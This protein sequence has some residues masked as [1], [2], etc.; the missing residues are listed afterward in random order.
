MFKYSEYQ[1]QKLSKIPYVKFVNDH[2]LILDLKYKQEL[3]DLIQESFTLYDF[4]NKLEADGF[5]PDLVKDTYS[6]NLYFTLKYRGRP[7]YCRIKPSKPATPRKNPNITQ[8]HVP[9]NDI[10][11]S[12]KWWHLVKTGDFKIKDAELCFSDPLLYKLFQSFPDKSVEVS[13]S[14]MGFDPFVIGGKL[15]HKT[16]STFK[17]Y[18]V[19][20]SSP[21]QSRNPEVSISTEDARLHQQNPL[22]RKANADGIKLNNHF[23]R[24]AA[25]FNRTSIDDILDVFMIDHS[26]FTLE[27]KI[28]LKRKLTEN[29]SCS[30][31]DIY[32]GNT[33]YHYQL[34]K[35]RVNLLIDY[36]NKGFEK[37]RSILPG[38]THY[39]KKLL[40]QWISILPSDPG[41]VYNK[42]I[43]LSKIG[44]SRTLYYL[45]INDKDFGMS[46]IKRQK[47][48]DKDIKAIKKV[49]DYKGFKKGSR[50]V[51]ILLPKLTGKS[52]SISKIRRLMKKYGLES[53]IRKHSQ[54]RKA[55]RERDAE[56]TKPNLLK[57]M[58]RLHHPNEVRVTDVTYLDYGD[59]MRA[60][61]SAL[62]DP[63]TSRLIAF[64]VSEHNDLELALE[65][66]RQS[67]NHPCIDGGIFHSDQGILYKT[68][69]FQK[70]V[71]DRGFNQSMSKKGNCWDNATQES[72]FGH[73]K[74]ECDYSA[75]KNL[76]E[77]KKMVAEYAHYYNNERGMWERKRMTPI[78][79]EE[80]LLS[81][82]PE[83]FGEYLKAEKKKYDGMKK[84]AAELAK[85]HAKTL[86][87]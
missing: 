45:Y 25:I 50:Q 16:E 55:A 83:E 57:R 28:Q 17:K 87:V 37:I 74:D 24:M 13:L 61:G 46:E 18:C 79:Y 9:V 38:M 54:S 78:E 60:Y 52:F 59:D 7:K 8:D 43:I 70:E 14:D 44:M 81:L 39:Q 35:N 31:L 64:V 47:Q 2:E 22:V 56:Y 26:L 77:L 1:I 48:D 63:V 12:S 34:L 36:A 29:S 75:C 84:K 4:R 21:I 11:D 80:Y 42:S 49:L 66:I 82:S 71:L 65:T 30:A 3:Y 15:I 20:E 86:G 5:T 6:H 32:Y 41:H 10:G 62:M 73:F 33:Y 23:F 19:L 76:N 72:F 69:D 40:C 67:D 85:K 51:Y 68:E 58:F 27:E 53:G